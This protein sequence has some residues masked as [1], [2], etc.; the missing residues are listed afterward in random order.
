MGAV[1]NVPLGGALLALEVF[2]GSVTLPLL[3][4]AITATQSTYTL[5]IYTFNIGEL[6]WPLLF[7][8]LAGVMSVI[9]PGVSIGSY[10]VIGAGVLL[11]ATMPRTISM[12]LII[13]VNMQV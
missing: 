6:C 13:V 7:G 4:P 2:L 10:A 9:W 3:L 5:P 11:A 12:W 1:Y 8:L